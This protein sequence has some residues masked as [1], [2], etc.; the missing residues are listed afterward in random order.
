MLL[1]NLTIARFSTQNTKISARS[2][3][4]SY[5]MF[6]GTYC[7][8]KKGGGEKPYYQLLRKIWWLP[9]PRPPT[10]ALYAKLHFL[11]LLTTIL[12]ALICWKL[13]SFR[14]L[15][16]LGPRQGLCPL[17]PRH[18]GALRRA[19]GTPPVWGRALTVRYAHGFSRPPL[20]L[21]ILDPPLYTIPP[22][23]SKSLAP[24]PP[25]E[26]MGGPNISFCP[27]PPPKNFVNLK[28]W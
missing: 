2:L 5:I 22:C 9:H 21:Q 18:W 13:E 16:P 20:F 8:K 17:H 25:N 26:N 6:S 7:K 19:P 24:P 12:K 14:G 28:N 23:S 10:R 27:S 1:T 15:R 3:A 4:I 11:S